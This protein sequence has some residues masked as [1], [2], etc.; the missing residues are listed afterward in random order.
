MP[1]S[2]GSWLR[3][4]D[5]RPQ[6]ALRLICLPHGGGGASFFAGWAGALPAWAELVAV[7]YPGREDRFG[8]P[9]PGDLHDLVRGL[10]DDVEPLTGRP[11]ALFGHS[12]G[13]TVAYELAHELLGRGRPAPV[14]LLVSGRE[15]PHDERGGRVHLLDDDGLAAELARLGGTAPEVLRDAGL[16]SVILRYVREDYGLIETYRPRRRPP[17]AC[18]VTVLLGDRDPDLTVA[19]AGRW[20]WATH[21][22]AEV[23]VFPG[24]HFYLVPQRDA[25]LATLRRVLDGS[26]AR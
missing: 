5:P 11:Y 10:A 19:E 21:G 15:A 17:L 25:V 23:R 7:Q 1:V 20:R 14:H 2:S 3:R 9:F 16:R 8:D 13:A 4:F 6:A 18:P 22:P 24:D 26:A 12:M